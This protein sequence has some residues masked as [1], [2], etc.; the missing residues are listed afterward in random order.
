MRRKLVT[1]GIA[2]FAVA[3]V[4]LAIVSW[5]TDDRDRVRGSVE[6]FTAAIES[7]DYKTV[8]QDLLADDLLNKLE[9]LQIPCE[10]FM[11]EGIGNVK[12]PRLSIQN[13]VVVDD[14][15]RAAITTEALGQAPSSDVMSL[16][17]QDGSWRISELN[18]TAETE[19]TGTT[20]GA[21]TPQ[22]PGVVTTP[23]PARG[24]LTPDPS[25]L[26]DDA[27]IQDR[28]TKGKTP[29]EIKHDAR[30]RAL[31]RRALRV[32]GTHGQ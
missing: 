3:M 12:D 30:I 16:E 9:K 6:K 17:K 10:T 23:A 27:R 29:A 20:S 31:Q 14:R 2:I 7:R 11:R 22:A 21:P 25:K 1:G 8:C 32:Q 13:V 18:Q 4:V 26:P 5:S 24:D 15:A 28:S 19:T